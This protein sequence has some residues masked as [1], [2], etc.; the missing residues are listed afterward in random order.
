MEMTT[1][2]TIPG[3][4]TWQAVR[5]LSR[6]GFLDYIGELW[7]VHG[8][9]FQVKIFNRHML[10]A[11][12][13]DAVRHVNVANRQNYDKLQSYDVVRDF[14]TGHGLITSTGEVWRR[15]RKL[16]APFYTPKGVQ[17]YGDLMLRDGHRLL[18]RWSGLEG[19]RVEIGEEMTF[20]TAAIILRAMFSMDTDEAIIS[21]KNAVETMLGYAGSNQSGILVPLW[22]PTRKNREYLRARHMV[23]SYVQSLIEQ[24]RAL[25][26]ADWP[27]DLLT[28]LMQARDEETGEPISEDLLRDESITTFFAGHE[29]TARTLTFAWYALAENPHVVEKLHAELDEVLG[30]RTPTLEDLHHLPYTLQVI[31]EVLRLYPPAPFYMRD[32][33]G[34]DQLGDFH[35][36]GLPVLL[37]PYYTHRHPDFWED[38]LQFN[39]ERWTPEQEASMHPYAY[40]PFAAGQ[41]ICIGNNFSLLESHI[42]LALLAR[43][44]APRLAPGFKPKFI[45]GGTLGTSNGF[46]MIIERR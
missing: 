14:I 1:V 20:V 9:V 16:M 37:S 17:A 6:A 35:T 22:I 46:P 29:T 13:P 18:Q 23:H 19:K 41:R 40:H 39:P 2:R 45:M 28:R 34:E 12:H 4:N 8:D 42:L 5:G 25:P 24:R 32:A 11:I 31:K 15:Q 44:Y 43:E 3:V 33:L 30:D 7:Q 26:E 38:P 10:V 21:M 36:Q 27:N